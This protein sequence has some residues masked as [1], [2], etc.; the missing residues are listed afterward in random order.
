MRNLTQVSRFPFE[1]KKGNRETRSSG[2]RS[3]VPLG[4]VE[5]VLAFVDTH[6]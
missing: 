4:E 3:P 6:G 2:F 1:K 5:Q